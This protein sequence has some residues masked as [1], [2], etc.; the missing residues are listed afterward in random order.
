MSR[1]HTHTPD[2][3]EEKETIPFPGQI[4][5][6]NEHLTAAE[7]SADEALDAIRHATDAMND[8]S[9]RIEDLARQFNC[10]GY[11]DNDDG[12]RAA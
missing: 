3:T 4:R 5:S 6:S 1:S 11:F 8:V 12:P 7:A 9:R 10:L 2:Q